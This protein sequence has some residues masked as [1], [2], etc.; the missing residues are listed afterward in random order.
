[1][2]G[3]H[4]SSCDKVFSLDLHFLKNDLLQRDACVQT[5]YR[6]VETK[7]S[8]S[9]PSPSLYFISSRLWATRARCRKFYYVRSCVGS[10]S[11][12]VPTPFRRFYRYIGYYYLI[13]FPRPRNSA[14]VVVAAATP[15]C[16]HLLH[17]CEH[18]TDCVQ[19]SHQY[20]MCPKWDPCINEMKPMRMYGIRVG[21]R[22]RKMELK[23][24]FN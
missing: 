5:K 19:C 13:E 2:K 22:A 7:A 23:K 16:L 15:L 9:Q 1:M 3:E 6:K 24:F 11:S 17:P 14:A 21:A 18:S 10:I 20:R 8:S 12:A 4:R